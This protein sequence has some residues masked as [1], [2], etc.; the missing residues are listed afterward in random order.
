MG[1]ICSSQREDVVVHIEQHEEVAPRSRP[2]PIVS[3]DTSNWDFKFP[4]MTRKELNK[5]REA[6]WRA[7]T[8]SAPRRSQQVWLTLKMAADAEDEGTGEMIIASADISP[9]EHETATEAFCYDSDNNRYDVPLW[10]LRLPRNLDVPKVENYRPPDADKSAEELALEE[11]DLKFTLRISTGQN[12]NITM[13]GK[14]SVG[15]LRSRIPS[16]PLATAKHPNVRCTCP[17]DRVRVMMMGRKLPDSDSLV[18]CGVRTGKIVQVM[19][20]GVI[21]ATPETDAAAA[22]AI[23]NYAAGA[24][25]GTTDPAKAVADADMAAP[26]PVE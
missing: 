18:V 17:L 14:Q 26:V 22:A 6:F 9:W 20:Q 13:Q 5:K 8:R 2:K 3:V 25:A 7:K 15:E 24:G 23:A 16:L 10:V 19:V 11:T 12:V 21:P 4:K 1:G